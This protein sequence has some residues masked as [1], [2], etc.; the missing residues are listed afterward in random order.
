M[1]IGVY[2]NPQAILHRG[3]PLSGQHGV[4]QVLEM[5]QTFTNLEQ[6]S[7]L[8]FGLQALQQ[9]SIFVWRVQP[10]LEPTQDLDSTNLMLLIPLTHTS[11]YSEN[12][13]GTA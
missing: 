6:Q 3:V 4:E 8:I 9:L 10:N 13:R 1:G 11:L 7:F 12:I 2:M 5:I